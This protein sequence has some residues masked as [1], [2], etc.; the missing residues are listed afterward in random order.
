MKNFHRPLLSFQHF[1]T[2]VNILIMKKLRLNISVEKVWKV[3][4]SVESVLSFQHFPHQKTSNYL[5]I[6]GVDVWKVWNPFH[7]NMREQF[8]IKTICL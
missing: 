4:E 2:L 7:Y 1:H 6:K 3:L 5:K 8:K